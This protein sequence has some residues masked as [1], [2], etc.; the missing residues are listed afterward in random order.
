[1]ISINTNELIG[2][3]LFCSE[4]IPKD[5]TI[6]IF[7]G[8]I[9][10]LKEYNKDIQSEQVEK[11]YA[12]GLNKDTV[13]D[14]YEACKNNKCF[15]SF[16]NSTKGIQ[17]QSNSKLIVNHK[18]NQVSLLSIKNIPANTEI[19]YYYSFYWM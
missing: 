17:Q 6:A 15:A 10:S 9:K 4:P 3:G 7:N 8:T 5:T 16:A 2:Q 19:L 18:S 13:L 12:V 11:G 1:M 14:C